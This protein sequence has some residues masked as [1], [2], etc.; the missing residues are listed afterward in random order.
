MSLPVTPLST[1]E[2]LAARLQTQANY[3][4]Q[5]LQ[6]L[7][8]LPIDEQSDSAALA[9][10]LETALQDFW[11]AGQ[12]HSASRSSALAAL[13]R[14]N[15]Y[16]EVALKIAD[17]SLAAAHQFYLP[18]PTG[19]PS[20]SPAAS[21]D[22]HALHLAAD[23]QPSV[24]VHG[25]LVFG[26]DNGPCLLYLP[27]QGLE[28]F[29]SLRALREDLASR[30][31]TPVAGSLLLRNT[32]LEYQHSLAQLQGDPELSAAPLTARDIM[33]LPL[34]SAP[35]EYAINSLISKQRSDVAWACARQDLRD[36]DRAHWRLGIQAALDIRDLLGPGAMLRIREQA[37]QQRALRLQAPQWLHN[38][39]VEERSNWILSL[40]AYEQARL[41]LHSLMQG[42]VSLQQFA[43]SRLAERLQN[44]LGYD[45]DP[46]QV[47]V[48]THRYSALG[49]EPYSQSRT[50]ETLAVHGLHPGDLDDDSDFHTATD[51]SLDGL[52]LRQ[53]Y[54][55]LTAQW[56]ATTVAQL[57]LRV[58]FGE[59]QRYVFGNA[60]VKDMMGRVIH[61]QLTFQAW[62]ALYQ[63]HIQPG[64]WRF[65]EALHNR[66]GASP[67]PVKPVRIQQVL[68]NQQL[69]GQLLLFR[70]PQP[71]SDAERLVLFAH[72]V[73]RELQ[74]QSFDNERQ[75]LH[76]LVSWSGSAK[77]RNYLLGQVPAG[78]RP[79]LEAQLLALQDKAQPPANLL[80]FVDHAG[81][82]DA[83]YAL[84]TA[85]IRLKIDEHRQYTP[86]WLLAASQ[87]QRRELQ[88]LEDAIQALSAAYEQQ[89]H[90]RTPDYEGFVH[91]MASS[92][93]NALLQLPDETVDPDQL[94]IT[95]PRETL[96]YTQMLRDGYDDSIGFLNPTAADQAT[97][98]G[99][100]GV[101]LSAL[102]P[103]KVAGSVR[104]AWPSDA[105]IAH[106]KQ[107]LLD[108][109]SEGYAYR[110]RLSLLL[111]QLQ[112]RSAAL[113]SLLTHKI[114]AQTY[115]WLKVS[116]DHM[117]HADAQ[118]R[119]RYPV[120][121]LRF[122]IDNP[123]IASVPEL[124]DIINT[125]GTFMPAGIPVSRMET[126]LGCYILCP[127]SGA[128][129]AMLY[130]PDAPDGLTFRPLSR[131]METLPNTGMSD[132]YRN[133]CHKI[134][135][136][137][138]AF[139]F[140]DLKKRADGPPPVL[141]DKPYDDLLDVCYNRYLQRQLR[142]IED[143]TE[144]RGDMLA[145]VV[146]NS[147]EMIAM[148]VTLPFPPASFAVGVALAMRDSAR[149]LAA[150]GEGDHSAAS[151][152]V[153][154]TW[155]NLFGAAGDAAAGLK[156][157]GGVLRQLADR[158]GHNPALAAVRQTQST[159]TGL[160]RSL[161]WYDSHAARTLDI[162]THRRLVRAAPHDPQKL[163]A[164][165]FFTQE[166]VARMVRP[167]APDSAL[168]VP[169]ASSHTPP[170]H[171]VRQSLDNSTPIA[172]GHAKGVTWID[173]HY[174]IRL[175]DRVYEVQYSASLRV[176]QIIDPANPYAFFGKQPVRLTDSGQWQ[177]LD[178]FKLR[179]GGRP[180]FS[181]LD[182]Q[183][184]SPVASSSTPSI[185]AAYE[186][187]DKWKHLA[188]GTADDGWVPIEDFGLNLPPEYFGAY[189]KE[190]RELYKTLRNTLRED[191]VKFFEQAT[192]ATRAELP[193]LDE[194][195]NADALIKL[196]FAHN[197]GL[198]VSE[199]A[200]SVASK[201]LLIENM[202]R[203]A[204]QN[205]EIIYIEHLFTDVHLQKLEK[206]LARGSKKTGGSAELK[207]HL[208]ELNQ[209]V[210]NNGSRQKHD[211][212]HLIKAAHQHGIQIKPL[213]SSVSYEFL[214]STAPI[215]DP[216]IMRNM[217]VFFAS[218]QIS[219]DT[220]QAPARRWVALL[221]QQRAN[222]H[223]Q[224]PGI[225]ELHGA[226]SLRAQDVA[227]DQPMRIVPDLP[228]S[229]GQIS[230]NLADWR[231]ELPDPQRRAQLAGSIPV[232]AA[233]AETQALDVTLTQFLDNPTSANPAG[234]ALSRQLLD[235]PGK[236]GFE[237][238]TAGQWQRAE[239][240]RW[241]AV[242]EPS[243]L[244]HSM[245][246]PL[247]QM[248]EEHLDAFHEL[249]FFERRGLNM[250]YTNDKAN[251]EASREL[252]FR[253]RAR[254][255]RD[256]QQLTSNPLPARPTL[257]DVTGQTSQ[258]G[259]L[260]DLYAH[261][262]GLV[263]AEY[264]SSIASKQLIID[265]LPHLSQ[266]Q[267][268]T[269]YLE[270]L[271]IDVHQPDLDL[272]AETGQM[273]KRLLHYLKHI[274]RGFFT[275]PSG[276]Y[277]FE[278]LIIKA[279]EH[280]VEVRA[281]DCAPGYYLSNMPNPSSN[282]RIIM[283]NYFASRTIRRHQ[284]VVGSHKWLALV[285]EAHANTFDSK[286]PG[287]AELEQAI[288]LRVFDMAP[289]QSFG[290]AGDPGRIAS[291]QLGRHTSLIRNDYALGLPTS[292][293][294]VN[295]HNKLVADPVGLSSPL[296]PEE[297][298]FLPGYFA[299]EGAET[300][301]P[302]IVHRS[303]ANRIERTPVLKNTKGRL[304][305][306]R[307]RWRHVHLRPFDNLAQLIQALRG[308]NLTQVS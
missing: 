142:D 242:R 304:Y 208:E 141:P 149:A 102:S 185:N 293:G 292:H 255:L 12:S 83:L 122:L 257:P 279:R 152:H 189:F 212:Y 280:G 291:T 250:F 220:A 99:P 88:S 22:I 5:E 3:L 258:T 214:R 35:F 270:H 253:Q 156:G 136:R 10:Q 137:I 147:I 82:S 125:M 101:D 173:G 31:D 227:R 89:P 59:A 209:G 233:S 278:Q 133:R 283:M 36:R 26:R 6:T 244:Q 286:V 163:L 241:P 275:D 269:L 205:V 249:A 90:T 86:D 201:R 74:L 171:A 148:A 288:S 271:Q 174:Y 119:Q 33:L 296:P 305:I 8:T 23:D 176:W 64:D 307:E 301:S 276:R 207:A 20:T 1:A 85:H 166:E 41:V 222:T 264:H 34:S 246:D 118:S 195:L 15:L 217:S 97:F 285:G 228:S 80:E 13:F 154:S 159:P 273:S 151:L 216:L 46:Q 93:L 238:D 87:E 161:G 104:G 210:L 115:A 248:P 260:D 182:N 113:R 213:N 58:R 128:E 107:T 132:Y 43:S 155:L 11:N 160:F 153:L 221:E 81:F 91:R 143:T 243:A 265:N 131:F 281:L 302:V 28:S 164:S 177:V 194:N 25:V 263:I 157:F 56:L 110:R 282:D 42:C 234:S 237:L 303:R 193:A 38:A 120:H 267:I 229:D 92:K 75:L 111:V 187:P 254:L 218:R 134:M 287:L 39:S 69:L 123:F 261:T 68:W 272:F 297:R 53:A 48:T 19:S 50:L 252:F 63:G 247:Y 180:T 245:A 116:I 251:L 203:L 49:Q 29:V 60:Q 225:A 230:P 167:L 24:E 108:P 150:L 112:M 204:E 172:A 103:E 135:S 239:A 232:T 47:L 54:P 266:K 30:L 21:L 196:A 55:R 138:L 219:A 126:A 236:H 114:N 117:H 200:Q 224:S 144:G 277:T 183:P 211:Y 14:Q 198:V 40:N 109:Q 100:A 79:T 52:S 57:D 223:Q 106:V 140:I 32:A 215:D 145:K 18:A 44:E 4:E 262:Q 67:A 72:N 96:S 129:Q 162:N 191:A 259:L 124:G 98:S 45:L 2:K 256:A 192:P 37:R 94:I 308:M 179:G 121:P 105:W 268:K 139:Y 202:P 62:S 206:Y 190:P 199:A 231:L 61:R 71:D 290:P 51:F 284:Q 178:A 169:S 295:L 146:L 70:L 158:G 299:I 73:P 168:P 165:G 175:D 16:D 17:G 127:P 170:A 197:R 66:P 289:E 306:D 184:V 27:G 235:N 84:T 65:T 7:L 77:L 186:L 226:I 78:R 76:E 95:S 9:Q 298:L 300:A 294:Q 181:M 274:D 240:T 130:T 188:I